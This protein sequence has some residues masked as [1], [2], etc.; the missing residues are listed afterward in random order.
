MLWKASFGN[1]H[2]K[3]NVICYDIWLCM[4]FNFMHWWQLG[5]SEWTLW[6]IFSWQCWTSDCENFSSSE[7]YPLGHPVGNPQVCSHPVLI[8]NFVSQK[9]MEVLIGKWVLELWTIYKSNIYK[10]N[11]TY[12]KSR[13]AGFSL[14]CQLS[15][16]NMW[17]G[18]NDRLLQS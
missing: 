5:L 17:K 2:Y 10:C 4:E 18:N 14:T 11:T 9:I 7:G 6:C 13:K 16:G 8:S 12:Q 1:I 3:E 15:W